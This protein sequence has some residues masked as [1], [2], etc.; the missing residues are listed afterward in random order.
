MSAS[1]PSILASRA[2]R[3]TLMMSCLYG[4]TG[5]ILTFLPRWLS[6][7]RGLNGAE[8]GALLA[9]AQCSRI[10]VGPAI[11]FWADGAA[12]R[13]GP[14]RTLAMAA[15][16]SYAAFFFLAHNFISLLLLGF[17]A[18]SMT[19]AVTPLVE[20]AL[21]RATALGRLSY[22]VGRGIGSVAFIIANVGSG[23]VVS[24]FGLNA[25]VVW[26]L[27][28]LTA[29]AL[30]S[31]FALER[32]APQLHAHA[33]TRAARAEATQALLRNRRYVRLIIACGL[34]QGAHAFYYGFSTLVWR[35]QGLPDG[36]IGV[37]WGFG[38]AFEV[39]FLWTLP[40]FERRISPEMLIMVGAAGGVVRWVLLGIA[41]AGPWL[42]PLQALHA[43]SFAAAH[44]GAM[45]L[46]YREAPENAAAMAQTLYATLSSGVILGVSTLLSGFL[47]DHVG[48]LGYWAMA[49][50]A[51]I[52]ALVALGLFTRRADPMPQAT[53]S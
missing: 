12:D 32:D 44:I 42:W 4:T 41:P 35:S 40:F 31:L 22:G 13:R 53:S 16:A 15:V 52:G 11:A 20:G 5:V 14:M 10:V 3:V 49:L 18:L 19:Q 28:G 36:L 39:A 46:L 27:C 21:L 37:L 43:L 50:E 7:E 25:V 1:A 38:V 6:G 17:G 45:R 8:I 23:L 34:I 48:A 9:L 51:A 30:S 33:F 24:R 2:A 29:T 26:V 47:F